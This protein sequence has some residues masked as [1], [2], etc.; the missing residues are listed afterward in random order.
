M[1]IQLQADDQKHLYKNNKL[2]H[3]RETII[4]F[5]SMRNQMKGYSLVATLPQNCWWRAELGCLW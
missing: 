5:Q 1:R 3:A 2:T 4:Q